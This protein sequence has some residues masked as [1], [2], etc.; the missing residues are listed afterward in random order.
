MPVPTTTSDPVLLAFFVMPYPTGG[1]TA[2]T[3]RTAAAVARQIAVDTPCTASADTRARPPPFA[4]TSQ[5]SGARPPPFADTPQTSGAR[6]PPFADTPQT[7][8]APASPSWDTGNR[9]GRDRPWA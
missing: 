2:D 9:P 5:T 6:P 3:P 4:D 8:G 7:S 1:N